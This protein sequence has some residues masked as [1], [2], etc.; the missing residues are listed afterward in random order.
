MLILTATMCA[1]TMTASEG[2]QLSGPGC[3]YNPP[4]M[5]SNPKHNMSPF[6]I[7]VTI[8]TPHHHNNKWA[9]TLVEWSAWTPSTPVIGVRI[10]QQYSVL[11]SYWKRTNINY[12]L[13]KTSTSLVLHTFWAFHAVLYLSSK[14]ALLYKFQSIIHP[15][16]QMFCF[17]HPYVPRYR[18]SIFFLHKLP[19]WTESW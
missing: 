8:T 14:R 9:V 17:T 1:S 10:S 19:F 16:S 13:L 2:R 7:H 11:F 3:T 4:A 15:K 6:L 18:H 12:E 5:G